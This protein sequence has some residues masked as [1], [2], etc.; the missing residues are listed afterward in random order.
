[1]LQAPKYVAV[2]IIKLESLGYKCFMEKWI[3]HGHMIF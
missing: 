1:M 2:F 3:F